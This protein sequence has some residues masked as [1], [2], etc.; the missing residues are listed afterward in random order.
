MAYATR[1]NGFTLS[2]YTQQHVIE[3]DIDSSKICNIMNIIMVKYCKVSVCGY[4]TTDDV[5]WGKKCNRNVCELD[6]QIA[7]K[8]LGHNNSNVII[9]TFGASKNVDNLCKTFKKVV[10]LCD[11]DCL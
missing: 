11:S 4:N 9:T 10:E 1:E 8:N 6:F 7:V 2:R 5:Y 3:C